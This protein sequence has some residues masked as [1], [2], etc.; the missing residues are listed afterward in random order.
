MTWVAKAKSLALLAQPS[1][2][3]TDD[4][5]RVASILCSERV[6]FSA[7]YF[8]EIDLVMKHPSTSSCLV[9]TLDNFF[10]FIK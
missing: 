5:I 2:S 4:Q 1:W 3:N 9:N 6:F 8:D 10:D 7:Q